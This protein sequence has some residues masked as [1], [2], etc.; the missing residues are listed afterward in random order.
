MPFGSV[1]EQGFSP[2]RIGVPKRPCYTLAKAVTE[3]G[4]EIPKRALF[5]ASDVCEIARVQPYVLRSWEAEFPRLGVA[6]TPGGP[7]VYRRVDVERVLEIKQLVYGEGLTLSGARRRIEGTETA[8][9]AEPTVADLLDDETRRR[10]AEVKQGLRSLL[11]MLS[12]GQPEWNLVAESP[13]R[14]DPAI[15]VAG[16][17]EAE[18]TRARPGASRSRGA[19]RPASRR[20]RKSESARK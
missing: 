14:R 10:L 17:P 20:P 7:R 13:T 4:V 5:K 18:R 9:Q 16:S 15:G 2:A 8:A 19:K 6:R 1:V 3:P 11:E 12:S